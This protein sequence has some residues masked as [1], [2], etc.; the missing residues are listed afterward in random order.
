[1]DTTVEAFKRVLDSRDNATGGGAA[2]GIAGAMAAALA[3][4]VARLSVGR[5]CGKPDAFYASASAEAEQLSTELLDGAN[6]DARAFGAL[7]A[8]YKHPKDTEAGR[9]ERSRVIQQML[10]QATQVPLDNAERCKRVLTL[11]AGLE[12]CCNLTATSDLECAHLL[13][14][15]ALLG[16][17]SNVEANLHSVKDAAVKAEFVAQAR[18]LWSCVGE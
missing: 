14:R 3:A 11:C 9:S 8:A 13:A 12:G 1:M 15:A 17:L 6:L 4:M 18:E 2:S 16:C 5:G 10:V 7:S